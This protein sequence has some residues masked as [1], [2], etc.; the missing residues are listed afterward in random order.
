MRTSIFVSAFL[1]VA[2]APAFAQIPGGDGAASCWTAAQLRA[3]KGEIAPRPGALVPPPR[4]TLAPFAATPPELRGAIR[5]VA[6]PEG[7][8]LVALTFDLCEAGHEIAGYD[9]RIIDYLREKRIKATFF[10]GGKWLVTHPERAEQIIADPL[11]E[12]ANHGW[13]HGNFGA[14]TAAALQQE[15]SYA[16]AAYE[17]ARAHLAH[18]QCIAAWR[19]SPERAPPRMTLLRFP[20]GICNSAALKAVAEG[21][22]LAIQWDVATGDPSPHETAH[23]IAHR[24]LRNVRPGSIVLG[25]ANG[26]GWNTAA[27]LALFIPRLKER[28]Y[29]FVTVSELLAAGRP[30]IVSSCYDVRVGDTERWAASARRRAAGNG[31]YKPVA[32]ARDGWNPFRQ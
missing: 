13:R 4:L 11:F 17:N 16:Q 30:E 15:I 29:Q 6:L 22:L 27:A 19:A 1:L 26:R 25:H 14:L 31:K 28:G 7:R 8:K 3:T 10:A 5:R 24:V 20:Y 2:G 23:T 32:G 12:V 18:R 9:G 21:G